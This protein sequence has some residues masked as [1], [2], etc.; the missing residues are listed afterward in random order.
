[1]NP[2]PLPVLSWVA[3]G[4]DAFLWTLLLAAL[5]GCVSGQSPARLGQSEEVNYWNQADS[6]FLTAALALPAAPGPHPA[7]VLLSI[8]GTD[9]IVSR[10]LSDGYAVLMP[11]RRGFVSVE[12]LLR[13]TYTDLAGDVLAAISFLDDR[14]DVSTGA[15]ALVGQGD[16]APAAMLAAAESE[17]STPL[18]LLEPPGM[19]GREVFRF[20]Q[21][22]Q[23]VRGRA[24]PA[25]LEALDRY[26]DEIADIIESD[27]PAYIREYRLEGLIGRSD[28]QL[29]YNAAFPA[30]DGGQAHFLGSPLWHDRLTFDAERALGA[31]RGPVLVIVGADP[32]DIPLDPHLEAV[33]RGLSGA[34]GDDRT[35]CLVEARPRHAFPE[36]VVTAV[37]S[38]LAER[39]GVGEG[40]EDGGRRT[41]PGCL[42]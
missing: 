30:A 22:G 9:P 21:R 31:L 24:R 4:R 26:I 29:P 13:A 20:E 25:D 15:I 5:P 39:I 33:T 10:L 27:D 36:P 1:M 3:A 17:V 16:D 28:V 42:E 14:S 23:A 37:G 32:L 12:P 38:W 8:A 35:V 18:V 41:P 19:P 2:E 34:T 40:V 11:V 7:V 6:T